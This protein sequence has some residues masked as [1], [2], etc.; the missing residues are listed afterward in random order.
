MSPKTFSVK[1]TRKLLIFILSL[2]TSQCYKINPS[3]SEFEPFAVRCG[4]RT[5]DVGKVFSFVSGLMAGCVS[6]TEHTHF[7]FIV[8]PVISDL[9]NIANPIASVSLMTKKYAFG[10]IQ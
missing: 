5:L 8:P 2:N 3:K 10:N 4:L 9:V 6:S 7:P 1:M